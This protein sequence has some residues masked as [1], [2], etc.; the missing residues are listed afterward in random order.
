LY[1]NRIILKN[2]VMKKQYLWLIIIIFLFLGC[3]KE[4][5]QLPRATASKSTVFGSQQGLDPYAFSF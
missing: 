5:E 4:L 3:E 1:F 2:L